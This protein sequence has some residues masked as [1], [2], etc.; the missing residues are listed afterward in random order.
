[1][2]DLHRLRLLREL[3]H[4]GTLAAVA[5][6]LSYSPSTISQQLSQLEIEVGV[7]L[8]EPVGRRVQLTTEAEILVSHVE[9]ILARLETAEAEMSASCTTL[10]GELRIA[11]FQTAAASLVLPA[12]RNLNQEH[13]ELEVRVTQLEPERALPALA[14]H[15]F[16]LVIAE[17]YP[18]R[19]HPQ[20]PGL[21]SHTLCEDPI[22]LA[23][24]RPTLL[25]DLADRP[26]VM[27][28]D[29]TMPGQWALSQCRQAG[30][31]PNV[32][33]TSTDL[34]F[35]ARLIEQEMAVGFLPDLLWHDRPAR[36]ALTELA[37][38]PTRRVFTA[39]RQGGR[40]HPFIRAARAALRTASGGSP[41]TTRTE[42]LPGQVPLPAV[43]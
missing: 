12:V 22:R 29:D 16:D 30:F 11:T 27:E 31:E 20:L 14:A 1:V 34:T 19:P 8:L 35:H 37:D 33:Y 38:H 18:G 43:V 6:A 24:A 36:V 10:T 41:A 23:A 21:E 32:R 7:P 39:T 9:V 28:P 26:W 40:T 4:R 15:D 13:P 42:Q 25:V 3:K 2:Y 5:Q 17:E